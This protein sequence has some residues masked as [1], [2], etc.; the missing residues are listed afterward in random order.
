MNGAEQLMRT[1]ADNGVTAC[2]ANPGTTEMQLVAA[3]DTER[4]IR[5]I[6]GLFEGV[7]T[8][9][10]DGFARMSEAPAATILHLGPGLANGLANLHNARRAHS[11]IVNLVGDHAT[12]HRDADAPLTSDIES[13][14]GP[15][16]VW[17]HTTARA[18]DLAADGAAAV[19]A[20]MEPPGGP[21]TLIIPQDTAWSDVDAAALS[22]PS[23]PGPRALVSPHHVDDVARLLREQGASAVVVLGSAALRRDGL[24]AASRVA[25]ATGC[26]VVTQGMP[27]RA[28][29]GGGLPS[30]PSVPYFPEQ[31]VE[32]FADATLMVVAG[33]TDPVSF[34][35]YPG[36]PSHPRPD[37]CDLVSL[38][39]PEEDA[40][41]ALDA[42]ASA[43]DAPASVRTDVELPPLPH[44][45]AFGAGE[46]GAA[47]AHLQP[48][49][50]VVVDES[51]TSGMG[52]SIHAVAAPAHDVLHLTGGA[53]GQGLPVAVGAAVACPD[54]R[55]IALQADGSGMYTLQA[56]WTMARESLDVT[57][58]VLA[59]RNYRILQYELLR[60][61]V[62]EPG[63]GAMGLT[64]LGRPELDW[65]SLAAGMG[66]DAR[67]ATTSDQFV[68]ALRLS[69]ATAGPTLIEAVI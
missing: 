18:E 9:A 64:D 22:S 55:V 29:R 5:P 36:Q 7:A 43:L 3:L 49:G 58:V 37:S 30:F 39:G 60:A 67:R 42:L 63:P 10:A 54:R 12:W 46:L 19:T 25:A 41:H 38:A 14:A 34:F 16:S 69:F 24:L 2:F 56:L 32:S 50:A 8:G 33:T 28:E 15:M 51:I 65:V 45:S 40:A 1:L 11:P 6:L 27:S 44:G 20:S 21:A 52:Y 59:N 13:L 68:E 35:G 31:A 61:G 26:R 66:V 62:A 17:V 48:E 47:L 4:R 57:V 53:I 23:E